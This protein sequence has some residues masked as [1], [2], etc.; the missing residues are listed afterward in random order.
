MADNPVGTRPLSSHGVRVRLACR[1][2]LRCLRLRH[3]SPCC[4][5]HS[6]AGAMHCTVSQSQS[7]P[8]PDVAQAAT[9]L[10]RFS[11][12][13]PTARWL[14]SRRFLTSGPWLAFAH[15]SLYRPGHLHRLSCQLSNLTTAS[16]QDLPSIAG[17][18]GLVQ[19]RRRLHSTRLT[20]IPC[21]MVL[22]AS[23]NHYG[24]TSSFAVK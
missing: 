7:H 1:F 13:F 3:G 23:T 2:R 20:R 11:P 12:S 22:L 8:D 5:Q 16:L 17:Q 15:W 10:I 19:N 14:V 21:S 6:A 24:A 18:P 9:R 4:R